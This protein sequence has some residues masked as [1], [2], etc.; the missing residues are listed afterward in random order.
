M[1]T[2]KTTN[3]KRETMSLLYT[4]DTNA[5]I[6]IVETTTPDGSKTH[7]NVWNTRTNELL[8]SK[9]TQRAARAFAETKA[10]ARVW[11]IYER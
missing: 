5:E 4:D 2:T 6:E 10:N 8:A 7:W 11:K 3:D 1:T 9:T